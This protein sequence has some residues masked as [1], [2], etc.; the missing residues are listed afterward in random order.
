MNLW[1]DIANDAV[2]PL[3]VENVAHHENE[4]LHR[5]SN[6]KLSDEKRHSVKTI[7]V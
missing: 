1:H 7:M 4:N 5:M 2:T 3:G 6:R